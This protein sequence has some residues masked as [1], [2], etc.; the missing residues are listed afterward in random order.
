MYWC[1]VKDR[2]PWSQL[3]FC[4][5]VPHCQRFSV[6]VHTLVIFALD[7]VQFICF[8]IPAYSFSSL[9]TLPPS[10]PLFGSCSVSAAS[11]RQLN[12]KIAS[13]LWSANASNAISVVSNSTDCL[14]L[15][16]IYLYVHMYVFC[17]IE[18]K[19]NIY[20]M[21]ILTKLSK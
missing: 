2:F 10:S 11:A 15:L 20:Y 8:P 19:N 1:S 4:Y 14:L 12:F 21:Y 3:E 16:S 5:W 13:S 6:S 18:K 9:P 7:N 17:K